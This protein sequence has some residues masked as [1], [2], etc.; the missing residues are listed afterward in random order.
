MKTILTAMAM[1]ATSAAQAQVTRKV[2]AEHFTNSYC[3]VCAS[4]NPGFFTNMHSF[5]DVLHIAYYP[6]APYPA[7]PLNQHNKPEADART[8]YYG[9]YGGTPRLVIEGSVISASASYTDASLFTSLLGQTSAFALTVSISA[10]SA[11]T[12][13]VT[14]V[15]KKVAASPLTSINI[16]GAIVED[17]LFFNAANGENVHYNVFRKSLWATLPYSITAPAAVG[18]S[19]ILTQSFTIHSAWNT[20]RTSAVVMLQDAGKA[21]L[22][23]EKSG[24]LAAA[25]SVLMPEKCVQAFPNPATNTL[26]ISDL[27]KGLYPVV[28]SDMAGRATINTY[29]TGNVDIASLPPGTWLLRIYHG[30]Q[31]SSF[32]FVKK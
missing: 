32:L 20:A 8:N 31:I 2:I 26:V 19:V 15:V 30:E 4:R 12:G 28:I 17:T 1:L 6:S 18:D 10:T 5:P 29:T 14:T 3:S 25:A 13:S 9:V 7:C 24:R 23:A 16:Y 27:P 11:T 22:Q 21:V